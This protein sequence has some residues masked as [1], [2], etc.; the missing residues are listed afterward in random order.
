MA[1]CKGCG[2]DKLIK[3]GNGHPE[4]VSGSGSNYQKILKQ[5]QD[6]IFAS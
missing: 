2:C 5:V 6:C 1:S 4:L 3:N